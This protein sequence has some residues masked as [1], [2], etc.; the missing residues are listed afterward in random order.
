MRQ[1]KEV[2]NIEEARKVLD[3]I[4]TSDKLARKPM[5]VRPVKISNKKT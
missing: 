1:K 5:D 4:V 2:E 3:K